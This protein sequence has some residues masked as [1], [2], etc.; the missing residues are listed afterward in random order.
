[1]FPQESEAEFALR[2][3][4][5]ESRD[6]RV[7]DSRSSS[8]SRSGLTRISSKRLPRYTNKEA[9]QRKINPPGPLVLSLPVDQSSIRSLI[10][11]ELPRSSG[12]YM[13]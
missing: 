8:A 6:E 10:S 1:M 3:P 2:S 5:R 13:A 11:S 7:H 4:R 9:G 12:A